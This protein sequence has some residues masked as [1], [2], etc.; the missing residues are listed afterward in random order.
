LRSK[1]E[2]HLVALQGK[3]NPAGGCAAVFRPA[4][5][6]DFSYLNVGSMPGHEERHWR[7]AEAH[8]LAV[9][10]RALQPPL[11]SRPL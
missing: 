10:V 4:H 11:D 2:K 7:E 9:I 6:C 8:L 1:R 5:R 3:A